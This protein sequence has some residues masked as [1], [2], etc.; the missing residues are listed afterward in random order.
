MSLQRNGDGTAPRHAAP[1]K[2][3]GGEALGAS[4]LLYLMSPQNQGTVT[5]GDCRAG[6]AGAN[7]GATQLLDMP[8]PIQD[9]PS[10]IT[11][12]P[13]CLCS[14]SSSPYDYEI[15]G[16]LGRENYKEMYLFIYR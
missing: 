8:K 5:H 11:V 1:K 16:P 7:P 15:S 9:S 12:L 4:E 13:L 3:P 6:P 14:A 10:H 2:P